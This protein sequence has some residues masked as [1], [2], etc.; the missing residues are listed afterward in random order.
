[1]ADQRPSGFV[2]WIRGLDQYWFGRE[3]PVTLGLFRMIMSSLI[4]INLCMILTDF[5]A[6]FSEKGFVPEHIAKA[7][8]PDPSNA[9]WN[10]RFHFQLPFMGDTIPRINFLSGVT[11]DRITLTFYLI[12]MA[13]AFL[14]TFGLWTRLTSIVMALGV[15]TLQHRNGLI[16]HGGDSVVR[17]GALYIAMAPSGAAC[18]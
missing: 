13:A 3:S 2:S 5:Q 10:G 14:C 9:F 1:L 17:I 4:F 16:L 15:V 12:V 8:L 18:S 6:W 7:Y 11:N